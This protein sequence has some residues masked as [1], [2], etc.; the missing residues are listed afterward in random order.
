MKY[1]F[2]DTETTGLPSDRV[3]AR[4]I[5]GVWPSPVSIAWILANDNGIILHSEY[6][7]IKPRNWMIPRESTEIHNISHEFAVANGADLEEV[8]NRFL[9]YAN[10]ADVLVAH[11]LHFDMNVVNNVLKWHLNRTLMLEDYKKRMF[12][13]ML[14]SRKLVGLPGKTPGSFKAPKLSEM[15]TQLFG[16]LPVLTL[17][18]AM[19]DTQILYECFYKLWG[20]PCDLPEERTVIINETASAPIITTLSISIADPSDA[21]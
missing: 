20:R 2:F 5:Q 17:H 21:V 13:T 16:S 9:W 12:C 19:T 3:P 10:E 7:I 1:L 18:N 11:N 14:N 8:F 15:Y 6:H 4:K